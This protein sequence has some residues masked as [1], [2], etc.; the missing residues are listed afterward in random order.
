[1]EGRGRV[2]GVVLLVNTRPSFSHLCSRKIRYQIL[3]AFVTGCATLASHPLSGR[4]GPCGRSKA[5]RLANSIEEALSP[6]FERPVPHGAWQ[7]AGKAGRGI[8]AQ[9]CYTL[10]RKRGGAF[11]EFVRWGGEDMTVK[12]DP[13]KANMLCYHRQMDR[14]RGPRTYDGVSSQ[15]VFPNGIKVAPFCGPRSANGMFGLSGQCQFVLRAFSQATCN[16]GEGRKVP[17]PRCALV[18]K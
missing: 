5:V 4:L 15:P 1:M 10:S 18:R 13:Q 2:R 14:T 17:T 7:G 9:S 6:T 8:P 12:R 16:E 11:R 3:S